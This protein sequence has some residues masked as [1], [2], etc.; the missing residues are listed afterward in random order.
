VRLAWAQ[1]QLAET[2]EAFPQT[3]ESSVKANRQRWID[4]S[5]NDL[6]A[7]LHAYEQ[8]TTVA[9][10]LDATARIRD[11]IKALDRSNANHPWVASQTLENA[12]NDLFN[13]PNLDVA[14]DAA[15]VS[16]LFNVNLVTSGPV[17]RKGYISQVTAGPKT[18]FGLM[19]SDQS[20][21]FYN[22]QVFT[23][24]TP[25][26]DFQNQIA[27]DPQG[28]RAAKLYQ[29]SA[30]SL[31]QAQLTVTTQITT[32][33]LV[34]TP[35]Y[36]HAIDASI[37]SVPTPGGGFGR[38]VAGVIGMNQSRINEKVREGA[39]PKFQQQ[40]P[41]EAME[42]AQ[43]RIGAE[44]Y[45][46]NSELFWKYLKGNDTLS[47]KNLLITQLSLRSRPNAAY[48]GGLLRWQTAE[49]RGADFPQPPKFST[50]ASGVTADI[51]VGS[52][53]TSLAEAAYQR[54][55]VKDVKNVMIVTHNVPQGA[56]AKDAF[57]L[58]TN[59]DFPTYEKAADNARTAKDP[60]VTAIRLTKP[61]QPPIVS[62]DAR[63]NVVVI[64]RN[65]EFDL[66]VPEGTERL[67]GVKAKIFRI[68][69]PEVEFGFS[70]MMK[71]ATSDSEARI[72][73]RIAEF[74][75]SN[76]TKIIAVDNENKEQELARFTK[77][78]VL[79][80]MGG[81]LAA[82]PIDVPLSKLEMQGFA[83]QSIS[84][85]HPSGWV[86]VSLAKTDA[87]LPVTT[88]LTA[89]ASTEPAT[90]VAAAAEAPVSTDSAAGLPATASAAP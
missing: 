26:W 81:K 23:S 60:K 48:I 17:E 72:V 53:L 29:F 7:A 2:V 68:T 9:M 42:E 15:T 24:V 47:V 38:M 82:I 30:T 50:P 70:Y 63:E 21:A 45:Q 73:A 31:D 8:A 86:R 66:L 44:A 51:H 34:L 25:I 90:P 80:G 19:N 11:A 46:R 87:A 39:L 3:D 12:V 52:I 57:T 65:V 83:L 36:T 61:S 4:F 69:M 43:E 6:G 40:I 76:D 56:P 16:P 33:G 71:P 67:T 41:A 22:S 88:S 27:A 58:T 13:R 64:A 18:G 28:Q 59:V 79:T 89:P 1:R 5:Q 62:V 54:D 85:P 14:A 77:A 75:P 37:C 35:S 84:K 55:D 10:R 74:T 20:I 78:L 32:N 49:V